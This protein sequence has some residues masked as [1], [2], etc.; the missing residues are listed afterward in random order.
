MNAEVFYLSFFHPENSFLF[1]NEL[2]D[3]Y[4]SPG[5]FI[6]E[7]KRDGNL[8]Y[9]YTFDAMD[10]GDR[11]RLEL[12]RQDEGDIS[13]SL[14]VVRTKKYGSFY[15]SFLDLNHRFRYRGK[16][17][18]LIDHGELKVALSRD[19]QKLERVCQNFD[20]YFIGSTLTEE[21]D[22]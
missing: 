22:G 16:K 7:A 4:Y 6:A 14:Y 1:P 5:L 11:V 9:R 3:Q 8:A 21:I 12:V 20:F 18:S 19:N 13:S 17:R 2:P 15:F 10:S